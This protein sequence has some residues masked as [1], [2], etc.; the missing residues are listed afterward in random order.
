MSNSLEIQ[1]EQ[2]DDGQRVDV[3]LTTRIPDLTRSRVQ[4]AIRKQLV[5]IDGESAK[6]ST[7]ICTGQR[8][9][10]EMPEPEPSTSKAEDIALDVLF[11][12][13]W[14]IAINK[15]PAMVVH[16]AKGHWSGTLT[17]ALTFHFEKLSAVGGV[18][19]PGIVHRLDRDTSG[20]I[21]VAK[22]DIA[23]SK[24][25]VQFENR[26]VIKQYLAIVS[27]APDRDRDLIEKPIGAH[28]YQREKMAIREAHSTSRPASTMYEV[29]R[30]FR[31]AAVLKV[32]PKTGR[33]HQIRIHLASVGMP[34]LAD[35]LYG[36]RSK[37]LLSELSGRVADDQVLLDRQALHAERIEFDHPETGARMKIEAPIPKDIQD[38]IQALETYRKE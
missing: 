14:L 22:T 6:P 23:H 3:F 4:A 1:V 13:E 19:R 17:A 27:P 26:T 5:S 12:D 9:H 37:L 20:V 31:G 28:P 32:Y 24:I 7:R 2:A 15:P 8:V 16:P 38:T 29:Y 30:R 34:V 21:L 10:I 36:G 18:N 11:E 33:T 25:T 35:K